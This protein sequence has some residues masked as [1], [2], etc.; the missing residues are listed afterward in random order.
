MFVSNWTC[1]HFGPCNFSLRKA[2]WIFWSKLSEKK[3]FLHCIKVLV[4]CRNFQVSSRH[5]PSLV[6]HVQPAFRSSGCEFSALCLLWGFKTYHIPISQPLLERDSSSGRNGRSCKRH[7]RESRYVESAF[8]TFRRVT[9]FLQWRCSKCG[10]KANM[11]LL[12]ISDYVQWYQRCWRTG[13]SDGASCEDIGYI[14][15]PHFR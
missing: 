5:Q 13:V 2:Q 3:G 4:C 1:R 11:E 9:H 12:L 10:C 14:F 8:Q 15:V 7:S 6:R